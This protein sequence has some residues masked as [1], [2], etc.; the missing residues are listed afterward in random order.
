MVT[1]LFFTQNDAAALARSLAPLVHD[2][3]EGHLAEVLIADNGSTNSTADIADASGCNMEQLAEKPLREILAGARADW[4]VVLYPGARLKEGWHGA[5]MD[6]IMHPASA[7]ARFRPHLSG[8]WLSRLF[9]PASVRRGPL[10]RGLVISKRQALA[11][12][13][14][15][16]NS[17]EDLIRGLALKTLDAEIDMAPKAC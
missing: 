12:L 16:A 6:H 3:V 4:F 5:V 15:N 14:K 10:A 11:N 1:I 17:G 2:A 8:N 13:P 7:A 9:R